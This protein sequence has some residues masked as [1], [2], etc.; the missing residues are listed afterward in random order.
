MGIQ[1]LLSYGSEEVKVASSYRVLEAEDDPL[2]VERVGAGKRIDVPGI[3]RGLR[4]GPIWDDRREP[5]LLVFSERMM[6]LEPTTFCMASRRS[7]RLSYI[8]TPGQ[9]SPLLGVSRFAG[10]CY[11]RIE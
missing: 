3:G 9:Y 11:L 7:S 2:A 6:G 8:R 1:A 10:R 5:G 4:R